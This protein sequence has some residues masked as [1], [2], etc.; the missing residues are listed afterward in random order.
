MT[1]GL[2]ALCCVVVVALSVPAAI[3]AASVH[4]HAIRG[5]GILLVPAAPVAVVVLAIVVD[6][7][8]WLVL[9]AA[10]PLLLMAVGMVLRD[11]DTG[12]N[13]FTDMPRPGRRRRRSKAEAEAA[14][15]VQRQS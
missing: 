4:G 13:V 5:L 12:R 10:T 8:W 6:L 14:D 7:G 15:G 2:I 1:G 3:A 11:P 9:V